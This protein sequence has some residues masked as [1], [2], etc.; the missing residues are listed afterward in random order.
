M[1]ALGNQGKKKKIKM[2]DYGMM[3]RN[4]GGMF[5]HLKEDLKD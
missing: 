4:E 3:K 1:K 5:S 2:W